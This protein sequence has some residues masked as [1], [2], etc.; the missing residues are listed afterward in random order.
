MD[1]CASRVRDSETIAHPVALAVDVEVR[2]MHNRLREC[3]LSRI[4]V[5]LVSL[6]PSRRMIS[7]EYDPPRCELSH[8]KR[9][10]SSGLC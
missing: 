3:E 10:T 8:F 4:Q 5:G 6:M 1:R 9:S 7:F 2:I